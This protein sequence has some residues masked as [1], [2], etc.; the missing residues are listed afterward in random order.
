MKYMFLAIVYFL[1]GY[2]L[3]T[4]PA[5]FQIATALLAVV[6]ALAIMAFFLENHFVR[7]EWGTGLL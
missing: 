6:F 5:F 7:R 3:P 4:L 1:I 2:I